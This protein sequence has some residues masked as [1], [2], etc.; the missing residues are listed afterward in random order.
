MALKPANLD[1]L[2]WVGAVS[3]LV[4]HVWLHVFGPTT[5]SEALGSLAL[6]LFGLALAEGVAMQHKASRQRTLTRLF[7]GAGLAQFAVLF[8]RGFEPLNVIYTLLGGVLLDSLWRY[9]FRWFE[10]TAGVAAVFVVGALVEY[11][12]VGVLF[13]LALCRWSASRSD[14]SLALALVGLAALFP[15]NGNHWALAA[16]PV[17]VAISA[18]PRDT[19]RAASAFYYVYILQWP[20]IALLKALRVW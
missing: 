8:V 1:V 6:P 15:F 18:M 19:P 5:W 14:L 10:R 9:D 3:M 13:T 7:I 11:G 17:A 12:H 16:I 2:K 4:D 20:A